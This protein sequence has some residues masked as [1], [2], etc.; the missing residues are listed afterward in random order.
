[1][2]SIILY[3]VLLILL[4]LTEAARARKVKKEKEGGWLN[5]AADVL[6]FIFCLETAVRIYDWLE[7]C[8]LDI[9]IYI[10]YSVLIVL[11]VSADA[12]T[13]RF[14]QRKRT[15]WKIL[16]VIVVIAIALMEECYWMIDSLER[17]FLP[18]MTICSTICFCP[19]YVIR[20][21]LRKKWGADDGHKWF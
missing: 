7:S 1:M 4:V 21:K 13:G 6:L 3:I 18:I 9:N 20:Q 11:L 19:L 12:V 15:N 5:I 10:L 17:G 8:H 16:T 2:K 14:L